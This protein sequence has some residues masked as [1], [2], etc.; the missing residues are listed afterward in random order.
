MFEFLGA[1]AFSIAGTLASVGAVVLL[2]R[3][4]PDAVEGAVLLDALLV[5]AGFI[6]GTWVDIRRRSKQ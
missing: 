2:H 1:G 5:A 3:L 6:I 4:F